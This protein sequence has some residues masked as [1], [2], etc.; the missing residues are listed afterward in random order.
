M[1]R[2]TC[3]ASPLFLPIHTAITKAVIPRKKTRI[4]KPI[5]NNNVI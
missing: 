4:S 1:P 3:A 2:V 5:L